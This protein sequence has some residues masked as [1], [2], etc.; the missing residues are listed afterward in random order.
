MLLKSYR[1]KG[2]CIL[3][4]A[5]GQSVEKIAYPIVDCANLVCPAQLAILLAIFC[6]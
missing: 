2:S 1:A 5:R 4:Q 6:T 3:E